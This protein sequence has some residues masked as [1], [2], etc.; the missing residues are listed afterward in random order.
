MNWKFRIKIFVQRDA[1]EWDDV[2]NG[3]TI[4]TKDGKPKTIKEFSPEEINF[5]NHNAKA[6]NS[7]LSGMAPTELRNVFACTS[8]KQI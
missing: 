8:A 4:P 7:L 1:Y 5:L 3:I 6:M 2:E